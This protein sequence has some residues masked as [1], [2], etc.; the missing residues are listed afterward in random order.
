M[1]DASQEKTIFCSGSTLRI[2]SSWV[3]NVVIS[4]CFNAISFASQKNKN[5]KYRTSWFLIF[6]YVYPY[7]FSFCVMVF[8]SHHCNITWE[9]K[10]IVKTFNQYLGVIYAEKNPELSKIIWNA[11]IFVIIQH[12][13]NQ[14]TTYST[15]K[16]I[17][18]T[19]IQ[20]FKEKK[21][22]VPS[23]FLLQIDRY[24]IYG[25]N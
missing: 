6:I 18:E 8:C 4:F 15:N 25:G 13:N 21:F 1:T 24:R 3:R 10:L 2:L 16:F 11:F 9:L 5:I 20:Q 19:K 7:K 23:W 14:I 12:T 17:S 22:E